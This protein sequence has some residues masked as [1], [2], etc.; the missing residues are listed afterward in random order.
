MANDQAPPGGA[1]AG[2]GEFPQEDIAGGKIFAILGYLCCIFWLIPIIKKDNAFSLFHAK[3][4][5]GLFIISIVLNI[6]SQVLT[7]VH[8]SIGGIVGLVV[9]LVVLVFMI[10]GIIKAATGK[11]ETLPVFGEMVAGWFKGMQKAA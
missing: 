11:Y 9:G 4:A 8:A 3:Q 10:I 7:A 6:I 1:P 5:L 2:G